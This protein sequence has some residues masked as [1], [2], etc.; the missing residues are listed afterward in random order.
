MPSVD[1]FTPFDSTE[2][3]KYVLYA[4]ILKFQEPSEDSMRTMRICCSR[5]FGGCIP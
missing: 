1:T 5:A 4:E 2:M 3:R